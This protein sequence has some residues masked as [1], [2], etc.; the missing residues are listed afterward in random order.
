MNEKI[1]KAHARIHGTT[2]AGISTDFC[3]EF[4]DVYPASVRA[5][6]LAVGPLQSL[7]G[8]AIAEGWLQLGPRAQQQESWRADTQFPAV[9]DR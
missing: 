2:V 7:I 1:A 8:H 5:S 3:K 9:A 6:F 4:R